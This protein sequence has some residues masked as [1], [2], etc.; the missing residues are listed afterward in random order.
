[1]VKQLVCPYKFQIANY[2][3][4]LQ[5]KPYQSPDFIFFRIHHF[6]AF[7]FD[8]NHLLNFSFSF[9]ISFFHSEKG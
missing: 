8:F 3:L 9:L 1:M 2:N 7:I 6:A 4:K 5:A